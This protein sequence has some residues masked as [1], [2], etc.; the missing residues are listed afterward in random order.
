MGLSAVTIIDGDVSSSVRDSTEL[1]AKPDPA[2]NTSIAKVAQLSASNSQCSGAKGTPTGNILYAR[3]EPREGTKLSDF[4]ES[5][6]LK[7][8]YRRG[9]VPKAFLIFLAAADAWD[10]VKP[11]LL[12]AALVSLVLIVIEV[13]N[14]NGFLL[15]NLLIAS[16]GSLHH[17]GPN[18]N[19]FIAPFGLITAPY[20]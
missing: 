17:G 8:T 3:H 19:A 11:V 4:V 14:G 1:I 13:T 20:A 6:L 15:R 2:C 16:F 9:L 18:V 5:I 7:A 10:A 12:M